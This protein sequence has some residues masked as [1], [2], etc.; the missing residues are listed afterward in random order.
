MAS[1][2]VLGGPPADRW[3]DVVAGG[4]VATLAGYNYSHEQ[5]EGAPNQRIAGAI[6]LIGGWLLFAPFINSVTGVLLWN[7]VIIGVLVT[8]F[9]GYNVYMAPLY[10]QSTTHHSS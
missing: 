5:V 3:N 1:P 10:E 9:A 6:G 4:L 8:A 2:F 7:D